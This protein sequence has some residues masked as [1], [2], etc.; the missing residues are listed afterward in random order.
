MASR[1]C[2]FATLRST[3]SRVGFNDAKFDCHHGVNVSASQDILVANFSLGAAC[4]H[5]VSAFNY[6]VRIDHQ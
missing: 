4:W 5:G 6:T 2:C 1:I 3:K